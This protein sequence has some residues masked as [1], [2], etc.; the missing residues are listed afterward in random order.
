MLNLK[1]VKAVT[2]DLDDTLWPVWP[3][4]ERA[5]RLL[6]D[7]LAVHA[8]GA[9]SL[10]ADTPTRLALREAVVRSNP[11]L[12]HHLSAIRLESIRLALRQAG[13]DP[14]LAEAGFQVFFDA[15]NQVTLYDDALL[16]LEFL[17][18]RYPLVALSNGNAD[19]ARIGLGRYFS[20][21]ISAQTFGV[22]KPDPRIFHAAAEA[23][24]AAPEHT[25]HI[26]DDPALDVAG[27]LTAG[28]QAVWLSRDDKPWMHTGTPHHTTRCLTSLCDVIRLQ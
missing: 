6:G 7:W 1:I 19:I 18:A 15:R 25:L 2:L 11:D 28:M 10:F 16:A 9:A 3:A 26:G 27:A 23:V 4:I 12:S 5:E 21:S 8:P 13:E 22:A 20:A 14:A 17:A 24:G